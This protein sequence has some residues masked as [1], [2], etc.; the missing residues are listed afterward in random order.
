MRPRP[1][2]GNP[3]PPNCAGALNQGS[4][5]IDYAFNK[6]WDAYAGVSYME[7]GGGLNSAY[8]NDNMATFVT[9]IR[10]KF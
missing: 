9:G 3:T 10:L 1:L 8:L 2:S 7:N 5:L 6:H 4:F